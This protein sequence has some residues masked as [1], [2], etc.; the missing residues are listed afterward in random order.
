V[1]SKNFKWCFSLPLICWIVNICDRIDNGLCA[2]L[3]WFV[4]LWK[5]GNLWSPKILNGVFFL[6]LICW[7]VNIR[8]CIN[9]G[10]C[11]KRCWFVDLWKLG[12]LWTPKIWNDVFFCRWSVELWTFVIVY[13]MDY[14][15]NA[16]GLLICENWEICDLQNFEMVFFSAVDLLNCE[17]FW[18]Y[19]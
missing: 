2:K 13:M 7:I 4:D 6:L 3:C 10:L 12:N 11:A 1:I 8:D 16:V 19:K 15:R 5:L 14:V 17:N 9:N 18:S